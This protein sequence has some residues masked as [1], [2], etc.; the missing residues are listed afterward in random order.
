M[1]WARS[2]NS[3]QENIWS[4]GKRNQ[5]TLRVLYPH[6]KMG[7]E[8]CCIQRD[9]EVH[10]IQHLNKIKSHTQKKRKKKSPTFSRIYLWPALSFDRHCSLDFCHN[11]LLGYLN[12]P[13]YS[14]KQH[15]QV[16]LICLTWWQPLRRCER[17][18]ESFWSCWFA[19]SCLGA[20]KKP[21]VL[22]VLRCLHY[23]KAAKWPQGNNKWGKEKERTHS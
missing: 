4:N 16:T 3:C 7:A 23:A 2:L 9:T 13:L 11:S 17:E 20:A 15:K 1:C 22:S 18:L 5:W 6:R 21:W 14:L 8:S 10:V 12:H 19:S